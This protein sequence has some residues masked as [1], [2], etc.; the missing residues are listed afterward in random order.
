[1]YVAAQW[2][3]L[4][5]VQVASTL[6]LPLSKVRLSLG[7]V[8]GAFGGRE[9]LSMHVHA[10]MLALRTGRP[11]RMVYNREESFFGHVHRHPARLHYRHHA[12][13]DGR[14]VKVEARLL[15]D[16]GAY[17]STSSAVIGNATYF[18]CGPY[19]VPNAVIDGYAVRTNNPPCG[20]MRGFGAVQ[21]CF[22][23][24]S[25]MDE[26]AAAVGVSPVEI[27]LRNAMSDRDPEGFH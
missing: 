18:S 7:G 5:Q 20:A 23:H 19:R 6:G 10:C 15:L 16:G 24:E 8:G 21:A 11:V 2:L 17:A 25:Q 4:D 26:L 3:H 22:A 14:I 9:D 27:R 13:R 12:T 1:M